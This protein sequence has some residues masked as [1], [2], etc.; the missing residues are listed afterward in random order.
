MRLTLCS[1]VLITSR[2]KVVFIVLPTAVLKIGMRYEMSR[3]ITDVIKV[4]SFTW[5]QISVLYKSSRTLSH[6]IY[7][8]R[9]GTETIPTSLYNKQR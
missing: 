2:I 6:A 8:S 3:S 1:E 7:L 4:T 9:Y 5:I